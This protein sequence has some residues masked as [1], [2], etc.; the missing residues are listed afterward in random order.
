[1]RQALILKI[2]V[3]VLKKPFTKAKI[4]ELVKDSLKGKTAEEFNEELLS[5]INDVT[6]QYKNTLEGE[7]VEKEKRKYNTIQ[8]LLI[9]HL[10]NS[11][12]DILIAFQS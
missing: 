3:K 10:R 11:R 12:S 7:L 6:E 5:K 4:E 2:S 9:T 8:T 1:M